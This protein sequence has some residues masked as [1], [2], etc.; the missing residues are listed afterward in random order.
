MNQF[1]YLF[2]VFPV[3]F[4]YVD[5]SQRVYVRSEG[6]FSISSNLLRETWLSCTEVC[7]LEDEDFNFIKP[8]GDSK[9]LSLCYKR[10][11]YPQ[12]NISF[13]EL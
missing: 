2:V 6:V 1:L 4:T 8:R 5:I 10:S 11:V 3:S 9:F 7:L 13:Q 12:D